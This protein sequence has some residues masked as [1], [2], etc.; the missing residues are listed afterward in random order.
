VL[1]DCYRAMKRYDAWSPSCGRP[2]GCVSGMALMAEAAS[3]RVRWLIRVAPAL[4]MMAKA[5]GAKT[6]PPSTPVVRARPI[7][8]SNEIVEALILRHGGPGRCRVRRRHATAR[9]AR[10]LTVWRTFADSAPMHQVSPPLGGDPLA[11]GLRHVGIVMNI[12]HPVVRLSPRCTE[13]PSGTVR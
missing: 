5:R 12:I 11:A 2:E 10:S 9:R 6:R 1:A 7:D 13:L 4:S 3:S 8:R